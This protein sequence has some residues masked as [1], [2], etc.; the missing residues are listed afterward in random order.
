MIE[1]V[2]KYIE[3]MDYDLRFQEFTANVSNDNDDNK[4]K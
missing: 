2:Y 4:Y 3:K 1:N